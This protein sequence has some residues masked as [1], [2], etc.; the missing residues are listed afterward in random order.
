MFWKPSQKFNFM[1]VKA[2]LLPD[3]LLHDTSCM[4]SY[5]FTSE[6]F[7]LVLVP[8]LS[9]R[10]LNSFITCY[11][12]STSSSWFQLLGLPCISFF[13]W[14]KLAI[15]WAIFWA[16]FSIFSLCSNQIYSSVLPESVHHPVFNHAVSSIKSELINNLEAKT[17][18]ILTES[19]YSKI[20][21]CLLK[22]FLKSWKIS[23]WWVF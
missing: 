15:I 20:R 16:S 13:F 22:S 12:S 3:A 19:Y 9:S 18:V 6:A 17:E 8:N 7:V 10:C 23:P 11:T 4:S 14:V 5:D 21:T 2:M 1:I